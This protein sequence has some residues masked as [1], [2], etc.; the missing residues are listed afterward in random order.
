MRN[1]N[2]PTNLDNNI[3]FRVANALQSW[4]HFC[5]FQT[6]FARS[7]DRASEVLV[8]CHQCGWEEPRSASRVSQPWLAEIKLAVRASSESKRPD[9]FCFLRLVD[10]N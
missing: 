4:N 7:K 6:G 2:H 1:D 3:G 5:P 8:D 10:G 9:R